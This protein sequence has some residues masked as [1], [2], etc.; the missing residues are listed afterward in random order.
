MSH[1]Q[2]QG[3]KKWN[4]DKNNPECRLVLPPMQCIITKP[5][6]PEAK[7]FSHGFAMFTLA[8]MAINDTG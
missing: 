6:A 4:N 2:Q 8:I 5:V 1:N 3:Q 7:F